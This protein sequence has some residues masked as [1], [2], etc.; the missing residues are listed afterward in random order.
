MG[1]AISFVSR[2]F[3]VF[4]GIAYLI[5]VIERVAVALG[6]P[7][8]VYLSPSWKMTQYFV[9]YFDH[10]FAKRAVVGTMLRPLAGL[11][12]QP[13]Y[14]V[15]AVMVALNIA[16]FV[17]IVLLMDRFLPHR[18]GVPDLAVL[19]RAAMVLGAVGLVQV[20]YDYGRLD[21]LV[22]GL[23]L[24]IVLLGLRRHHMAA[25]LLAGL[26]VLV[27][28]AFVVYALP[29]VLAVLWR[30]ESERRG[31]RAAIVALAPV[32]AVSG[33]AA[34]MVLLF[35]NSESAAALDIGR[36]QAVWSRQLIE[37][38]V[39]LTP[40]EV[41][42]LL[43]YWTSLLLVLIWFYAGNKRRP[44]LIF[45]A[46]L[47]PVLLNLFGI[48]Q[49]RWLAIGF[50]VVLMSLAI[51]VSAFGM[52]WPALSRWQRRSL[53]LLCVPLGPVGSIRLMFYV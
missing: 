51:Q 32:V 42:L 7:G 4:A 29:L 21:H 30:A 12:E 22:Y 38:W 3:R 19:L 33:T 24:C 26:V 37:I 27:H 8:P 50:F 45:L 14:F 46:T 16:A 47:T 15:L 36:G 41:A 20:A 2:H 35:G 53:Y 43:G 9:N 11:F 1:R 44:D 6:E 17:A 5:G 39:D 52:R 40:R 18:D 13:Q 48:D 28:E 10:G 31:V 23:S 25:A 49:A 34:L